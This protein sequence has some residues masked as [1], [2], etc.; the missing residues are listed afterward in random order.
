MALGLRDCGS[1][2]WGHVGGAASTVFLLL[3]DVA[4]T[5]SQVEVHSRDE[6]SV[7]VMH[8]ATVNH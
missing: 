4:R 7:P 5:L 2:V 8:S 1:L 6:L 3:S